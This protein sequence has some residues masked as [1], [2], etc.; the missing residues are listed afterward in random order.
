MHVGSIPL[1][2]GHGE[3][4]ATKG[5]LDKR[6]PILF[7]IV[8]GIVEQWPQPPDPIRGRSLADVLNEEKV[9]AR[10]LPG[11]RTILRA[12][13][14]KVANR[15]SG[16]TVRETQLTPVPSPSPIP[17]FDRKSAVLRAL[18]AEPLLYSHTTPMRRRAPTGE[19]VHI[20]V[21]VSGSMDDVKDAFTARSWTAGNGSTRRCTFFRRRSPTFPWKKYAK[22]WCCRPGGL[23][24]PASPNTWPTTT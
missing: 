20:Y 10:Q 11:N 1:L 3:D 12:L 19:R 8:R 13:I 16:G 2:G 24:S 18:G 7:D 23:P 14:R 17:V 4:A 9:T 15:L 5:L 22:G 6:S 21:D